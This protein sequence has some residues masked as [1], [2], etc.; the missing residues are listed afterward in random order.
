M[1]K[2]HKIFSLLEGIFKSSTVEKA[3]F[4]P[5]YISPNGTVFICL[6]IPS[7]PAY[8]GSEPQ[9]A[10]G[11]VDPGY[12]LFQTAIK[13]A[14]EELGLIVHKLKNTWSLGYFTY[15]TKNWNT[16]KAAHGRVHMWAGEV[17]DQTLGPHHYES[18]KVLWLTISEGL[19]KIRHEQKETLKK[20]VYQLQLKN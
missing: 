19:N 3:G 20:F 13:E 17:S 7:D 15:E 11:E 5:Y 4:L 6:M 18:G 8:G 12:T 16:N 1:N 10:K 2:S 14:E 9:F